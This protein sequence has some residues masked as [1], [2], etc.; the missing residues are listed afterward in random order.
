HTY[1]DYG[2]GIVYFDGSVED[3]HF[4]NCDFSSPEVGSNGLKF[5]AYPTSR[6]KNITIHRCNFFNI[7]RMAIETVNHN[8]DDVPRITDVKVTECNFERLGLKSPYGM[9]VSLSGSGANAVI[10]NNKIFDAN[11]I[12]IENVA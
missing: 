8:N 6:S 11:D 7:G 1:T 10:S 12:G 4:E 5:A 9:A 3:I 2:P